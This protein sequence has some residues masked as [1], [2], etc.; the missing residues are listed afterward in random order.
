M[1]SSSSAVFINPAAKDWRYT[2]PAHASGS[3]PGPFVQA[4]HALYPSSTETPLVQRPLASALN[5]GHVLIKDESRRYGLPSFKIL[6]A[7][8][9]V[10]RAVTERLGLDAFTLVREGEDDLELASLGALARQTGSRLKIVTCTE[11]NWGRAVARMAMYMD[12]PAV[13]Y[14]SD[15]MSESTRE[16][17]RLEKAEV[18]VV[19]GDYDDA[20]AAARAAAEADDGSLLVMDI[21][22]EGYETVPQVC[23]LLP[24]SFTV[25]RLTIRLKVGG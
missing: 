7:S 21:S 25:Y 1:T 14:V 11:G 9:A 18:R 23:L 3:T 17:I 6:G 13:V 8:W 20:V 19:D 24:S 5:V 12:I 22:W 15:H 10:Y 16:Y 4:F 2:P